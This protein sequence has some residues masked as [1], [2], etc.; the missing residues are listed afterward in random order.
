M[1]EGGEIL[2]LKVKEEVMV[3]GRGVNEG[4]GRGSRR[5]CID[6]LYLLD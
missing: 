2:M 4:E 5:G 6:L 1:R 3:G